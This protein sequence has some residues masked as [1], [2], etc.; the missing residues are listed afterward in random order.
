MRIKHQF[1]IK[2]ACPDRQPKIQSSLVKEILQRITVRPT[3]TADLRSSFWQVPY[4]SNVYL[5]EDKIQ[6]W[7]MYLFTISYGSYAMD[8][9]SGD[10]WFSGWI[11]S[12][13]SIRGIRMPEFEVLDARIA[14]ALNRIIHNF[15]FKRRSVWRNRFLRGRQIENYAD[16]CTLSSKWWFSGI[17]FGSGMEFYYQWRKSHLM[18]SWKDCT[19]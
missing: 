17:R 5:L 7:S 19:N 12:W 11:K 3:T 14:S 4:S 9:R 16:Q 13:S 15:H 2:D 10:G 1:G 8:Q 6:D 18:T